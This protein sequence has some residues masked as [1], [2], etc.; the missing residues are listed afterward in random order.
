MIAAQRRFNGIAR[1]VNC[2]STSEDTLGNA[3]TNEWLVDRLWRDEYWAMQERNK[4]TVLGGV[5]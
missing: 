1:A 4:G 5:L 2:Y 3:K